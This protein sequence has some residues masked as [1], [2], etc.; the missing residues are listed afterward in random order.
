VEEPLTPAPRPSAEEVIQSLGLVPLPGEG[1]FFRETYRSPIS[2]DKSRSIG[3]AIYFLITPTSYS[4][5][6]R[7]KSDEMYHFYAGDPVELV[8]VSPEGQIEMRILG[9][10]TLPGRVCQHVVPA[11]WWQGSRL[12]TGGSWGLLGTTVW[13]GFDLADFELALPDDSRFS[14]PILRSLLPI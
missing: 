1:G 2:L 4:L 12:Q 3:T 8:L 14:S 11:G 10:P 5:L 13:P 7:L 9:D 6:H